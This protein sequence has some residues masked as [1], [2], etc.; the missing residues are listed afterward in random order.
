MLVA[1]SSGPLLYEC[2]EEFCNIYNLVYN[3]YNLDL[4]KSIK[5]SSLGY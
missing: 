3:I 2:M 4:L 5:Y 1:I